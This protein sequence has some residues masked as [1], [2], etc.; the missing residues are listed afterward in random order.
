MLLTLVALSMAPALTIQTPTTG[1][2]VLT[3]EEEMGPVADALIR[4]EPLSAGLPPARTDAEGRARLV[5]PAGR[6]VLRIARIGYI[7]RRVAVVVPA[8][9]QTAVTVTVQMEMA[10]VEVEEIT[11]STARTERLA[12]ETPI[13]VEVLTPDEVDEKT[14]MSPGGVTMMLN[15]T[16]G[17]RV[18]STSPS[19]GTGAVRILGL[20]G[21]YTAMLADGL[22]LYGG[23]SS[24]LGPLDIS[25][26]DLRQV[27]VIKGAASAL[28]GGQALGGVINLLSKPPSGRSEVLVN[29][30]TR[31]VTDAAAWLSRRLSPGVGGSLLVSG[32]RQAAQDLDD[33]GWTDQPRVRRWSVRPRISVADSAGR[34]L[35]VTAGYS[36]DDR[37][38]GTVEGRTAP[39][40]LPFAEALTSR[41]ADLG[42]SGRMPIRRGGDVAVRAAVSTTG[43]EREFGPGP[44]ERDRLST[45]FFEVT[46]SVA[47]GR[48]A[49]VLGAALQG[50]RYE[51][52]LNGGY[53]HAWW[54]PGMF[55]TG[56]HD[57]GP[58]TASASLR[59]DFHPE[60]GTQVT[61]RLAFLARPADA[62][63]VRLSGG[64][65]FA[66]ATAQIEETEGIGLRHVRPGA[67][68]EPEH[69]SGV[70]LDIAGRH[71]PVNLLVTGFASEVRDAVQLTEAGDS[72]TDAILLNAGEPTRFW[73]GEAVAVWRFAGGKLIGTYGVLH[74]TRVDAVGGR[75]EDVPLQPRHRASLDL[76][77][78]RP[79]VYRVGA[80]IIVYGRQAL[81]DD[82]YRERSEPYAYAMFLAMRRFGPVELVANF[83]NLFDV[84]QTDHAPLV[85]PAPGVGG[86]WTVDAWAPLDG[87][88]ANLVLRY[89]W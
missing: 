81:D 70:T 61:E 68:L 25:P 87:F 20:P 39:D 16:N 58:I 63:S 43:R 34:S 69:S 82:P 53:D 14:Q 57:I 55:T 59:A 64:T 78:E 52:Q 42:V 45:G 60:A 66:P 3:V 73:G 26:V 47:S 38:G 33:D 30:T 83:E 49:L 36:Y 40:G 29:H 44:D 71:G 21:Q 62:W 18:Q 22:P 72:S 28:Y 31:N 15:E 84:R 32:T 10:M 74:A 50:D 9:G 41:R 35:F 86:R 12:G 11:V 27:E 80:E 2:I 1:T 85:R 17:V 76:M 24:S 77:L 13:R 4:V 46:R 54:T 88:V 79:G 6:R 65:G 8:G 48:T 37:T 75:R 7:A 5:L 23:A 51:N 19:I 56:E 67:R 89:R